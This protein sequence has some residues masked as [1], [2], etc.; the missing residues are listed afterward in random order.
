MFVLFGLLS[1]T[2]CFVDESFYH[3]VWW[4]I[5]CS[6]GY[7]MLVY[8]GCIHIE[9]TL[10]G[11]TGWAHSV[12]GVLHKGRPIATSPS[13]ILHCIERKSAATEDYVLRL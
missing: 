5:L 8:G 6:K 9:R 1:K 10:R 4:L 3:L 2:V 12:I 13:G 11:V 7:S